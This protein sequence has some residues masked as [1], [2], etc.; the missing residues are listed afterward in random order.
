MKKFLLFLLFLTTA[1]AQQSKPIIIK[2]GHL[3][4][5]K[6]GKVLDHQLI[7]IEGEKI[8]AV[9][10]HVEMPADA[11]SID[12]SNAWVLPGLID[13]HTHM[14]IHPGSIEDQILNEPIAF[15]AIQGTVHAR[16]TLEAGFTTIRD[17]DT[18]GAQ[19]AD[20]SVKR[21]ID[22]GFAVGPRMFCATRALT[23][24][25]GHEDPRGKSPDVFI[26]PLATIVNGTEQVIE[27]VRREIK[28]GADWIKLYADM[29]DVSRKPTRHSPDLTLEELKAAVEEA[30]KNKV[31]VA[32]HAGSTEG[33]KNAALAG[34]NSIEHMASLDDETIALMVKKEIYLCPTLGTWEWITIFPENPVFRITEEQRKERMERTKKN[35]ERA[36]K[37][38]VKIVFGTDLGAFEHGTGAREFGVMVRDGMS[39]MAAIQSATITASEML[40]WQEKIGSIEPGKFADIIAVESNPLK[41]ITALERVKF[42]MKGGIVYRN[43]FSTR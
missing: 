22:E 15:R 37:G 7:L 28:Y 2:A 26:P 16:Q 8:K 5:V 11:T 35:F 29:S 10:S 41:D 43:E 4:D 23:T 1:P 33:A 42:V 20:V 27:E 34:V 13:C 3:I 12:L 30:H 32:A 39:P 6:A 31:P 24:L 17:L 14:L 9:G 25:G 19:F 21:A 18:E 36:L 38:G 40:G